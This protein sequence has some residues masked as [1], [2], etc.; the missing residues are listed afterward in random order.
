MQSSL[1]REACATCVTVNIYCICVSASEN[2]IITHNILLSIHFKIKTAGFRPI[3]FV[4]KL[5]NCCIQLKGFKI[6][7]ECK[8]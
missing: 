4:I 5:L 3:K 6:E 7:R 8:P 2:F 1:R